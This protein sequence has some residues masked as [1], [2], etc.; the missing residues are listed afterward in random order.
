[1]K[2]YNVTPDTRITI[3][4]THDVKVES[5]WLQYGLTVAMYTDEFKLS[6]PPGRYLEPFEVRM[7]PGKNVDFADNYHDVKVE[8]IWLQYGVNEVAMYTDEFK[9]SVPPGRYLEPFEVRMA[10]G[11]NVDFAD[12]YLDSH[13]IMVYT[14]DGTKPTRFSTQ[15]DGP[16]RVDTTTVFRLALINQFGELI[17][18]DTRFLYEFPTEVSS[19]A[20]YSLHNMTA[21]Y[22]WTPPPCSGWA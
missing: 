17:P 21:R 2:L 15:Y 4:A 7:A 18:R 14:T 19:L 10:P 8:S 1:M 13:M 22:G 12:N 3:R 5:I 11:K 9:L 16:I 20:A 6:V